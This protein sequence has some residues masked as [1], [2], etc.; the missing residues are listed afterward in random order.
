MS[1][2][3]PDFNEL[4]RRLGG[5]LSDAWHTVVSPERD[6]AASADIAA[7]ATAAAP[8]VWLVGKVQSG[9]SSIVQALTGASAAEVGNGFKACTAS[10]QVFDYP[11]DAPAI[12]FLDTRGLGEAGYDPAADIAVAEEQAH[13]LLVVMKATD[14]AQAAVLDVVVAAREKHP[15]WPVLVAQ[16][17]LHEAYGPGMG[18]PER[19]MFDAEGKPLAMLPGDLERSLAWQRQKVAEIPGAGP[20]AFVP[21]DFTKADDGYEPRYYGLEALRSALLRV[22]PGAVA[23]ALVTSAGHVLVGRAERARQHI[24]GFATAAAAAD[25]VPVAGAVAVPAVQAKMLHSLGEIHG[26][27]WDRR[28][29]GEMSGALGAGVLARM[30]TSFGARQVAK[31]VP[32]YGQTAGA[33]TAATLSFVTTYALGVAASVY[34]QRRSEGLPGTDGVKQAYEDALKSAFEMAAQRFRGNSGGD[35]DTKP[36]AGEPEDNKRDKS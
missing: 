20:I 18:H 23:T 2:K 21:L 14:T 30:V 12:R 27:A 36:R 33:A 7:K 29:V 6:P 4:G 28:M 34:L 25:V 13:L 17:S 11:A 10:A 22:A 8:V 5:T 9:K 16:T 3:F 31:L 35:P 24:L 15:A 26:V 1:F 19:Y 32:V